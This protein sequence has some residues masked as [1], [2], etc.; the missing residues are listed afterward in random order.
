MIIPFGITGIHSV[1]I[2]KKTLPVAWADRHT[3]AWRV[4]LDIAPSRGDTGNIML[5]LLI[6]NAAHST[7]SPT[8]R[9]ACSV[10]PIP[11]GFAWSPL[12]EFSV[13]PRPGAGSARPSA[14][15]W[16]PR[17]PVGKLG[18]ELHKRLHMTW[19]CSNIWG[20][21][22][23]SALSSVTYF[24]FTLVLQLD[25]LLLHTG[26]FQ[27]FFGMSCWNE[28]TGFIYSILTKKIVWS[29][30]FLLPTWR[31]FKYRYWSL[32]QST[33]E[34]KLTFTTFY[35]G[36]TA[37]LEDSFVRELISCSITWSHV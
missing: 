21:L 18:F 5:H 6:K 29:R 32:P 26:Q 11:P 34:K 22:M 30:S 12:P 8:V 7:F 37:V 15:P 9:T 24:H 35:V 14:A 17:I 19:S 20:V 31:L 33:R 2:S 1:S 23:S 36:K 13:S 10:Q 16:L 27:R 25:W 4:C 28:T 3:S